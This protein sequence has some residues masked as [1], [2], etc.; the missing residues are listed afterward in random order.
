[1]I[2]TEKKS[3]IQKYCRQYEWGE[4]SFYELKKQDRYI[5]RKI[6]ESENTYRITVPAEY[7]KTYKIKITAEP[8]KN[9]YQKVWAESSLFPRMWPPR[10]GEISYLSDEQSQAAYDLGCIQCEAD[11]IRVCKAYTEP[12]ILASC[13]DRSVVSGRYKKR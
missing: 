9:T 1:M 11:R 6:K 5:S 2:R 4:K 3:L 12:G 10:N 13:A 8:D 7:M